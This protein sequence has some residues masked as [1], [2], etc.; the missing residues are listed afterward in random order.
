MKVG[1]RS[2]PSRRGAGGPS[3]P[4]AR[5]RSPHLMGDAPALPAAVDP[6]ARLP[7]MVGSPHAG[8]RGRLLRR[9]RQ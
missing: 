9:D 3:G 5:D 8:E 2:I 4:V 1:G 6:A 7:A